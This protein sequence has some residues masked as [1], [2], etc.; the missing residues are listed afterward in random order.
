MGR[1]AYVLWTDSKRVLEE[2]MLL[3]RFSL[4]EFST[5]RNAIRKRCFRRRRSPKRCFRRAFSR[6]NK[7]RQLISG[8]KLLKNE[9]DKLNCY[10]AIDKANWLTNNCWQTFSPW[11]FLRLFSSLYFSLR[12]LLLHFSLASDF[13]PRISEFLASF[14]NL[15]SHNC[16]HSR[17]EVFPNEFRLVKHH[18]VR[19]SESGRTNPPEWLPVWESTAF[20]Q[21]PLS[22]EE[23]PKLGIQAIARTRS[24]GRPPLTAIRIFSKC[25]NDRFPLV[26]I[27]DDDLDDDL[28]E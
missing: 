23:I 12:F 10:E 13:S 25:L 28:D 1:L 3:R 5:E 2:R 19:K 8:R 21:A 9:N 22:N 11:I 14:E 4:K 26:A 16:G 15:Q 27:L 24:N 6:A 17:P 20:A 7:D 18:L